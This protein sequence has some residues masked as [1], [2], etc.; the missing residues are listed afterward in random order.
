MNIITDRIEPKIADLEVD[1][2]PLRQ[3]GEFV[4]IVS[5]PA[6][7]NVYGLKDNG[8]RYF[9]RRPGRV[10]ELKP[11]E[12]A[13]LATLKRDY[14]DNM[15]CR[16]TLL[17]TADAIKREFAERLGLVVYKLADC[18]K[19]KRRFRNAVLDAKMKDMAINI[20][21]AFYDFKEGMRYA[22]AIPH[23]RLSVEERECLK[24][25]EECID[26]YA[27]DIGMESSLDVTFLDHH[28]KFVHL[29]V[30]EWVKYAF[31]DMRSDNKEVV[32]NDLRTWF[33]SYDATLKEFTSYLRKIGVPYTDFYEAQWSKYLHQAL[34]DA[35]KRLDGLQRLLESMQTE[36]GKFEW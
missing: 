14:K 12:L 22:L 26:E 11:S 29:S 23:G 1:A 10:D 15:K 28:P 36:H 7:S 8:W 31:A 4:F 30:V 33:G 18:L 27:P 3:R 32:W 35:Y 24:D 16:A 20:V 34:L 13:E 25:I 2:V 19:D 5:V 21:D 9:V 6:T 17:S